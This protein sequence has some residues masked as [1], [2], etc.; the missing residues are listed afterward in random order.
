VGKIKL[1]TELCDM[2]GIQYP[3]IQAGMGG[4]AGPCLAAAVSNAGGL[5]VLGA[6]AVQPEMLRSWIR[7][8]RKLTDKPFGVDILMPAGT[9]VGGTDEE[10]RA[11][12]PQQQRDY[13]EQLKRDYEVPDVKGKILP[14]TM[15]YARR[16]FDVI[17]EEKAPVFC[18]GLGTPDWVI[19]MAHDQ[20]MKVI[21]LVGNVRNAVTM[22][23]QG[24]DIIVAQGHE[25]G[26]HT[27]RIGTMA[28]IPQVVDAISPTPV[29]GAG[30]IGD[31]RGLV[32]ALALG[33]VGV[34]VGTAFLIS[35]ESMVEAA[36]GIPGMGTLT[37][38]PGAQVDRYKQRIIN[39]S[40]EGTVVTRYVT[41][42]TNRQLKHELID[43]CEK[44]GVPPLGMP[45]Q[46][47]L[48]TDLLAGLNKMDHPSTPFNQACGQITG[49][50]NEV[51]SAEQ[52]VKEMVE[53]AS[54]ILE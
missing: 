19:P 6:T 13:V 33:A 14:W 41:G 16:Q 2:L 24:S 29:L 44:S 28:L 37:E 50:L 4:I 38:V 31:G 1:H 36:E 25:A 48:I 20:G 23:N 15:E 21:S 8:T 45:L 53:Q 17:L 39:S 54:S 26:G 9:L 43:R 52:I 18:S 10:L 7:E 47:V 12:I 49:M 22:K 11:Q 34:W 46:T 51:K 42:K 5:G 40:E 30:G 3:I 35:E 27:G 32:A